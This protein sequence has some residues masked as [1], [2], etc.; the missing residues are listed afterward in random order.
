MTTIYCNVLFQILCF[1]DHAHVAPDLGEGI[2]R[3]LAI[4]RH[5]VDPMARAGERMAVQPD[6]MRHHALAVCFKGQL[7]HPA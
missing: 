4:G 3:A 7:L 1:N 2:S 5:G 6:K